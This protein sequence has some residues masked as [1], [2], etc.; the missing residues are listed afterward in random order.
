MFSNRQP[1]PFFVIATSS[2][3]NVAIPQIA[4]ECSDRGRL[5]HS[6]PEPR[7]TMTKT[8]DNR[9]QQAGE[10]NLGASNGQFPCGGIGQEFD[11]LDALP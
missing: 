4:I 9:R 8:T 3:T 6:K 10:E 7:M 11:V 2:C 1:P 5:R